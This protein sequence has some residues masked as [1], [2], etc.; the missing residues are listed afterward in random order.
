M[1]ERIVIL[2]GGESG[3]GAA[4]LARAKGLD[5]F[6]SDSSPLTEDRRAVLTQND[7]EFEEGQHT[8]T[9]IFNATTVVKSPG[10]PDKAPLIKQLHAR[11]IPV[12]S[13][14][15]F[16]YRYLPEGAKV[17]A[18]TGTNGKTTTTL[19]TYHLLKEAGLNVALGGNVGTS[20]AGLIANGRHDYYVIEVSSFQLDGIDTFK[21]DVAVLLN[22]TPDH[23]DRYGYEMSNYVASK[24][25]ITKNLSPQDAF[26]YSADSAPVVEVI[27]SKKINGTLLT[28]SVESV[29]TNG[30]VENDHLVIDLGNGRHKLAINELPL[31]GKHNMTNIMASVMAALRVGISMDAIRSGLKTFV[32]APHRLEPVGELD[33]VRYIN[34][35]KATNVDA[36]YY[37][38]EGVKADIQWIVGGVDK[39]NEYGQVMELVKEKVKGIICMGTEN[40]PI[41]KAF[42]AT[43]IPLAETRSIQEA[44]A[45]AQQWAKK[46]QVVLLS[47]A[48]ASF[49]LFK[50]YEDRGNQFR[51]AVQ[52]LVQKQNAHA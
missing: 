25:L 49:D 21:P 43:G 9:K 24:F 27:N 34:D 5:V 8:E 26:I 6:L 45:Q 16:G 42:G 37:A 20:L 19:L 7:I 32:N 12:I 51:A 29:N 14:I 1:I 10:I 47:P 41:L 17:I 36:V 28:V 52:S 38:L 50:N 44:I 22:I 30:T 46:G 4:L 2:G 40:S 15:E 39:G 35:S 31:I 11:G 33:G 3:V 18:I 48:C 13:E 23:L